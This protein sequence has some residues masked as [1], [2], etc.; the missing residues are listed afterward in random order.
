MII[1]MYMANFDTVAFISWSSIT[2]IFMVITVL[3]Y[4][5]FTK[6]NIDESHTS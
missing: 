1:V 3:V 6:R 2:T 4:K 5:K